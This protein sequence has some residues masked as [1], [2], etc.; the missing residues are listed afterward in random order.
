M[1]EHELQSRRGFQLARATSGQAAPGGPAGSLVA[2]RPTTSREYRRQMRET[3]SA[4]SPASMKDAFRKADIVWLTS[5]A[6]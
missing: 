5:L 1:V 2:I 6:S 4:F 3:A